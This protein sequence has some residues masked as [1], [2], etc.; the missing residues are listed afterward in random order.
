[1]MV[2]KVGEPPAYFIQGKLVKFRGETSK[3][4]NRAKKKKI[5]V[6]IKLIGCF[7]IS[8]I[9]LFTDWWG[10]ETEILQQTS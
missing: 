4:S 7:S 8:H 3:K 1:M 5:S 2:D 9:F 10:G 6:I